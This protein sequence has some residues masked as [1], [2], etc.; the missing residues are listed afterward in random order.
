MPGM[1]EGST[2]DDYR[3]AVSGEGEPFSLGYEWSDKPH[4]LVYDLCGEVD[5]SAA[6]TVELETALVDLYNLCM[7]RGWGTSPM[8]REMLAARRAIRSEQ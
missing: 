1:R 6:R 7:A 4:R 3:N 8:A 5:K 2:T